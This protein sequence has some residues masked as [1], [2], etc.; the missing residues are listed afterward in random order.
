MLCCRQE[1]SLRGHRESSDSANRGNFLEIMSLV[2]AEHDPVIKHKLSDGPRNALYTS[3][4]IQNQLLN[5]MTC[6]VRES[7]C[8]KIRKAEVFSVLADETKDFSKKKQLSIVLRYVDIET[9]IQHEHFISY[10]DLNAES[11]SSYIIATLRDNRLDIPG[12][13]SQV[14]TGPQS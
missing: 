10:I 5:T 9:A 12:L 2:V 13:V 8:D 14:M 7:I 1:I 4:D 6:M 3:P 11:L